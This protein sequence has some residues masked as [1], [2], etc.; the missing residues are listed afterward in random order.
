MVACLG[1][2]GGDNS[3]LYYLCAGTT[4]T[5][6]ITD[7]AQDYKENRKIQAQMP[8]YINGNKSHT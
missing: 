7:M 4:A 5:K 3:F 6:P 1:D 2:G 8:P